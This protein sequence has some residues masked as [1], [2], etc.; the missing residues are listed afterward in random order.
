LYQRLP[1]LVIFARNYGWTC[2]LGR[3]VRTY[4]SGVCRRFPRGQRHVFLPDN[5]KKSSGLS[6]G[7][8]EVIC[9]CL[10]AGGKSGAFGEYFW[11]REGDGGITPYHD[12]F[13]YL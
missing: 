3:E 5:T 6:G 7:S 2:Y 4:G 8:G 13:R 1:C 12:Y 9:V 10:R 11:V